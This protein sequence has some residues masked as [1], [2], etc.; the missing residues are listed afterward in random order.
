[1]PPLVFPSDGIWPPRY[2]AGVGICRGPGVP[3]RRFV[4]LPSQR[5][6]LGWG[7]G[8]LGRPG[9][10]SLR[11]TSLGRRPQAASHEVCRDIELIEPLTSLSA[12]ART[13]PRA[14]M[15]RGRLPSPGRLPRRFNIPRYPLSCR[16]VP[17]RKR[18]AVVLK[19]IGPG[20]E[21]IRAGGGGAF[22]P[23]FSVRAS[24]KLNLTHAFIIWPEWLSPSVNQLA[25]ESQW[26]SGK[27]LLS[28]TRERRGRAPPAPGVAAVVGG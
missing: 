19:R 28:A 15:A 1:M 14:C 23:F 12:P 4:L 10:F 22:F 7:E 24:P 5:P 9:F 17:R 11:V 25:L 6:G 26:S 18:F 13:R 20:A 21:L 16:V 8:G 27:G 3:L 2:Y